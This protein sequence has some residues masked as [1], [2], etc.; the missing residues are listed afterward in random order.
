[1]TNPVK[2]RAAFRRRQTLRRIVPVL[3]LLAAPTILMAAY[4]PAALISINNLSDL[5]NAATAR[6]N[7]GLGTAATAALTS[8]FQTSNNLSEG[9]PATMR[10]NLGL[11]TI[12]TQAA[13]SVAITGG[14]I[15]GVSYGATTFTGILTTQS[16][17]V[18]N[19]R[20]VTAAGAITMAT[21]DDIVVVNKTTGAATAVNAVGSPTTGA[22]VCI[23]DGKGDAST[24]NITWTPAAGNVDGAA[25]YVMNQ[26]FQAACF[27]Y[28]G[29][30]W[31][32]L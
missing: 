1:M 11:G 23:K 27:V 10:T 31:N 4:Q 20:V 29:T 5:N 14:T 19:T 17:A 21:S 30:Q 16:G 15:S 2:R 7:L 22:A 28:N 6:T 12:A 8:I 25:T 13:S 24:N 32:I 18:R 3:L 9:T 26:N